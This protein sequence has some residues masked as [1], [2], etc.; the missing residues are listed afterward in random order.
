MRSIIYNSFRGTIYSPLAPHFFTM[1]ASANSSFPSQIPSQNSSSA[2]S[3]P[4][5]TSPGAVRRLVF[6]FVL[7][8][9]VL[10]F[11]VGF[12]IR[13][14]QSLRAANRWNIHTYQVMLAAS[15]IDH[16]LTDI[17]ADVRN[18]ILQGKAEDVENY[19]SHSKNFQIQWQKARNLTAD[20]PVQQQ[21]LQ[22]VNT[23]FQAWQKQL[24]RVIEIRSSSPDTASS[25]RLTMSSAAARLTTL[26]T[27]REMLNVMQSTEDD[28]LTQR[29]NEQ[30]YLQER[31]ERTLWL[32]A[33]FSILLTGGLL[34][35]AAANTRRLYEANRDLEQS[36]LKLEAARRDAEL[37]QNAAEKA[38]LDIESAHQT[39][40]RANLELQR[41]NEELGHF[42][43]VASH[44]LQEPLRAISGCVQLLQRRYEGQID[45]R[46]DQFISHA[47]DGAQRMQTLINDLLAYSRVGT[48][49]QEFAAIE[50]E[51]LIA[52][53]KRS[54]SAQI[55]ESGAQITQDAM[56]TIHGDAQQLEQVWQNF[57]SNAIKFCGDKTPQIHLGATRD[58]ANASWIFSV[59]DHGPGIE[60]QYFERIW[61]MFQRL[62]TRSEY[63]GTGI[64]LAIC[65]KIIERHGGTVSVESEA[66][67]GTTFSFSVP[68]V[69]DD[70]RP[71]K[72]ANEA[73]AE[74]VK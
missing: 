6:S 41:S 66:G 11:L 72:P 5:I 60:P 35:L 51:T 30:E 7:M 19:R 22:T 64:G 50:V 27:M 74:Q 61:V 25:L 71:L 46:A 37:A 42:A 24:Q 55:E 39:I 38:R 62:H 3:L 8:L 26:E 70:N 20:R 58:D 2:A 43:Y 57:L 40:E 47:V 29:Q 52:Q 36:N 31:T 23:D 65:K 15:D 67:E 18:F 33:V 63:P 53:V 48:R 9:G 56:P 45:A 12:S 69:P 32:G 28:L 68:D 54:L 59:S 13:N 16:T 1:T 14:F 44:D 49:D 17:D 73:G 4:S 21:R 34:V 10:L